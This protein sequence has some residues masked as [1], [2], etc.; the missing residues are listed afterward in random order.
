M[1]SS[2]ETLI[3]SR[4]WLKKCPLRSIFPATPTPEPSDTALTT[5]LEKAAVGLGLVAFPDFVGK[6]RQL[7]DTLLVRHGVMLV[8]ET[9]S[10]KTK[11]IIIHDI[12]VS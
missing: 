8:G 9:M 2:R 5:A 1:S 12:H 7:H 3:N 11:C 6:C 4:W 10:G